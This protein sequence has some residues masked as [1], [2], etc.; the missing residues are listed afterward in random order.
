[1]NEILYSVMRAVKVN[2]TSSISTQ[3]TGLKFRV[4]VLLYRVAV[5]WKMK[6]VNVVRVV[7]RN[8]YTKYNLGTH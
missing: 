4:Y 6:Q 7:L 5:L 8:V 2:F 1:M 3:V